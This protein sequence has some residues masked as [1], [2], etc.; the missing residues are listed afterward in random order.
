MTYELLKN[1]NNYSDLH[2]FYFS[3]VLQEDGERIVAEFEHFKE[4][5]GPYL[6][7]NSL[8]PDEKATSAERVILAAQSLR[9]LADFLEK[10]S[11]H[12]PRST[13]GN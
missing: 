1:L 11:E 8:D 13:Q 9:E 12:L 4:G 5:N 6:S 2:S 7:I 10:T 3:T